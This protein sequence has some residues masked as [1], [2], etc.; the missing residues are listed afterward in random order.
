MGKVVEIHRLALSLVYQRAG[1]FPMRDRVQDPFSHLFTGL[2]PFPL[3]VSI[4][5]S[6]LVWVYVLAS[7]WLL[8]KEQPTICKFFFFRSRHITQVRYLLV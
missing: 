2:R 1:F 7:L 3:L 4:F 5:H 8:E 6:D